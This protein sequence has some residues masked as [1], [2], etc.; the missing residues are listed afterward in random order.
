MV[1]VKFLFICIK[2]SVKSVPR[3]YVFAD[4]SKFVSGIFLC[5]SHG[6]TRVIATPRSWA[7]C[8]DGNMGLRRRLAEQ[9]IVSDD[10]R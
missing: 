3:K 10:C 9:E 2:T 6:L 4:I 1:T 7:A 5:L 8:A